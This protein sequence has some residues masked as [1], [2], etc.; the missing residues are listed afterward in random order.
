MRIALL[1][2]AVIQV[3]PDDVY[4]LAMNEE[5]NLDTVTLKLGPTQAVDLMD[6]M[7]GIDEPGTAEN[8]DSQNLVA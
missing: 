8:A 3:D 7:W 1:S 5:Y 4:R 2:G 6:K